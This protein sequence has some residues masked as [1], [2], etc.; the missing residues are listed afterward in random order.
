MQFYILDTKRCSSTFWTLKGA[1]LHVLHFGALK[2]AVLHF[3]ALKGAVLHFGAL[4]GAVLHFGALKDAVL[5]F[6]YNLF[7][8]MHTVFSMYIHVAMM[9]YMSKQCS[10]VKLNLLVQRDSPAIRFDTDKVA[11]S[12]S[13]FID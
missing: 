11:S 7:A 6:F 3:G 4:K 5:H 2:G 9:Q 12:F 1:V 8:T 10:T 13:L